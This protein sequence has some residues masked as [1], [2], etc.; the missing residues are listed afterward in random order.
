LPEPESYESASCGPNPLRPGDVK[1]GT[2]MEPVPVLG[3]VVNVSSM[4][5][6]APPPVGSVIAGG[7]TRKLSGDR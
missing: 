4:P 7:V 2:D 6:M 3:L 5:R 1:I